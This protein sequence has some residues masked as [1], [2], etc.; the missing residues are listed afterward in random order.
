MLLFLTEATAPF[1]VLIFFL[2]W[3]GC[4]LPVAIPIA[5]AL[6]WHPP[7]PLGAEEKLPFLASLYLI[8]PLLLWGIAK[9]EGVSFSIYG[10]PGN[11]SVLVSL[12]FGLAIGVISIIGVFVMEWI[13]GWVNWHWPKEQ[14]FLQILLTTLFLGLWVGGTEELI[15]RGFLVN[16]LQESYSVW[17]AAF[18]SSLIFASGHLVWGIRETLPQ[19]PG[20]FLLGLV[21]VLARWVDNG[22]LGLAIGLHAGWIWVLATIDSAKLIGYT[23]K[24]SP[25]VTGIGE[26]PLAGVAGIFC[27]LLTGGILLYIF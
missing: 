27:I 6:K 20:L 9:V 10:I 23:G 22:S 21:L 14:N 2:A 26:K 25:W 3:I 1:K 15:F 7:K 4:W 24:S 17:I 5:Y 13:F 19:L 11:F 16:V 8:A 12:L 18:V